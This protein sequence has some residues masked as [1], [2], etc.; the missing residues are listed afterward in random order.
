MADRAKTATSPRQASVVKAPPLERQGSVVKRNS[1]DQPGSVGMTSPGRQGSITK[2]MPFAGQESRMTSNGE[3]REPPSPCKPSSNR[4]AAFPINIG[5]KPASPL[6]KRKGYLRQRKAAAMD[7]L[8][9]ALHPISIVQIT[10]PETN[11]SFGLLSLDDWLATYEHEIDHFDS[12]GSFAEIKLQEALRL[13]SKFPHPMNR[14]RA[15]VRLLVVCNLLERVAFA[16]ATSETFKRYSWSIFTIRDELLRMVFSDMADD[17][18]AADDPHVPRALSFFI[19]KM[20]YFIELRMENDKKDQDFNKHQAVLQKLIQS[21]FKNI[22]SV[23]QAWK[24][25]AKTRRDERLSK[26][27]AKITGQI[28]AKRGQVRLTFVSWARHCL[29][30]RVEKHK[31]SEVQL[32][33]DHTVRMG[34]LKK[35]LSQANDSMA[36]LKAEL[37]ALKIVHNKQVVDQ[38]ILDEMA[39]V[40]H[41]D[42]VVD[43]LMLRGDS[44]RSDLR[45]PSFGRSKQL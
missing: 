35:Q 10:S 26:K 41:D 3:S 1:L 5:P 25:F 42:S 33:R 44:T 6:S 13:C 17:D 29:Q 7:G 15:A 18:V 45:Q 43:V 34:E 21:M 11:P 22:G 37:H 4:P 31:L 40:E 28:V 19:Q 12:L 2:P 32:E 24:M 30:K 9:H 36:L 27:A 38:V 23:F 39:E 16:L 14:F 8:G 20:P